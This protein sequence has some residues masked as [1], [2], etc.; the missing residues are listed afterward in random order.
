MTRLR[1]HREFLRF[2]SA[3]TVSDFGTYVTTLALQVLVVVT[4]HASATEV[5]IVNAARWLPYLMFGLVAGVLADRYRRR[6]ILVGT[7]LGRAVVLG[8]V[9]LL[10]LF[11]AL[12][13]PVLV[14]L[15]FVGGTLSV[16][17]DAAHQSFLPRLVTQESLTHANARLEQSMAVAQS[18]GPVLS[19]GLIAALGAPLAIVVDAASFLTSGAILATLRTA[20]PP[21]QPSRRNLRHEMREGLHYVYRHPMLAPYALATHAWF[22]FNAALATVFVPFVLRDIRLTP[23]T[24]GLA[25]A[26]GGV[27][28]VLGSQFSSRITRRLGTGVVVSLDRYLTPVSYSLV[29]LASAGLGGWIMVATGQ[30]LFWFAVTIGGPA[31]LGYR[32]SVT[33]DHLQGRMN[34]TIRS[35]NVGLAAFGAL[36]G[37]LLADSIGYRQTLWLAIGSHVAGATGLAL[38]RYRHAC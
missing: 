22:L 38:S 5:G 19:G 28:G 35:I 26:L 13:I 11:G 33:P 4:L 36:G 21:S 20:E 12:S 17:S 14:V 24:L 27:G 10:W 6:P 18:T 31:E 25:Y 16:Q 2:W 29:A 7:D 32:Q 3:S 15:M 1:E 8:L 23:L 34:A 30:F 37:G 9:P